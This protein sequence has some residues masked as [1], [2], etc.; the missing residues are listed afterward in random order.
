MRD[1]LFIR[2]KVII[3]LGMTKSQT[4]LSLIFPAS[5]IMSVNV[6]RRQFSF[7]LGLISNRRVHTKMAY[8]LYRCK[9]LVFRHNWGLQRHKWPPPEDLHVWW[10]LDFY[11]MKCQK[12]FCVF[13]VTSSFLVLKTPNRVMMMMIDLSGW[14]YKANIGSQHFVVVLT[15]CF[16]W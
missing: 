4:V 14:V 1:L 9:N 15:N 7:R 11:K 6:S 5:F 2:W 3:H 16:I 13:L 10:N 12:L 8:I